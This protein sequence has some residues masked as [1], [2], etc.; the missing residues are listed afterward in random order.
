MLH[1]H[2]KART[3]PHVKRAFSGL[4]PAREPFWPPSLPDT[5]NISYGQQQESKPGPP[6]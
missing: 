5:I 3:G 1:L 4:R 2:S 6:A